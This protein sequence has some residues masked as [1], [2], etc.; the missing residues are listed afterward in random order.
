MD[1]ATAMRWTAERYPDRRAVGG[2]APLTYAEWDFQTDALARALIAR[3]ATPGSRVVLML[4][5]GEPLASLH[6]AAQKA[7]VISRVLRRAAS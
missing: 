3:G 7:A 5:G 1:I 6:L 2:S 4:Q